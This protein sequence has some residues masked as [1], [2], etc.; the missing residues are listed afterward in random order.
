MAFDR[1]AEET[2]IEPGSYNH[3]DPDRRADGNRSSSLDRFSPAWD[4]IV[5]LQKQCSRIECLLCHA[6]RL[7][8]AGLE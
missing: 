7:A 4:T 6:I 5:Q 8:I 3:I 1:S 2:V